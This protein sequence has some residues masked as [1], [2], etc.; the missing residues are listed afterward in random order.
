MRVSKNNKY[1]ITTL[2]HWLNR[3]PATFASNHKLRPKSIL[4][5]FHSF[6]RALCQLHVITSSP[7]DWSFVIGLSDYLR[8]TQMRTAQ[9][10]LEDNFIVLSPFSQFFLLRLGRD[11]M[12]S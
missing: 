3:I 9:A 6:S 2:Q 8:Y 4:N 10:N 7:A 5:R 1:F 11:E 12:V